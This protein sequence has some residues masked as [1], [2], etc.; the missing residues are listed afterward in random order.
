MLRFGAAR[1]HAGIEGSTSSDMGTKMT[2]G[3]GS[4]GE[5]GKK[6]KVKK[7]MMKAW[8]LFSIGKIG[9]KTAGFPLPL[10]P[11][12]SHEI[13]KNTDKATVIA[14]RK[15][16]SILVG[17]LVIDLTFGNVIFNREMRMHF[18]KKMGRLRSS[19]QVFQVLDDF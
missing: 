18:L 16:K 7:Y 1:S 15:K 12:I 6:L 13:E 10:A 5:E 9:S 3:E 11:P 2:L 4:E 17:G 19:G 8:H 14:K